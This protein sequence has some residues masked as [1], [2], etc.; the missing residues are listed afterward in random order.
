MR[1][2]FVIGFF[3]ISVLSC[4]VYSQSLKNLE[5]A[6]INVAQEAG[7]AVVSISATVR[8]K[9]EGIPF[10]GMSF[11]SFGDE[12]FR[13]FFEEFFG[14]LPQR[15]YIRVG[16]GSGLII[17]KDGYILTNEHV[18]AGAGEIKV[19]LSDGREFDAVIRGKDKRSDLA[20]IKI[21][22]DN[23]LVAKLG[24]SNELKIGQWSLAIG[25]PFGFA[26]VNPEPT[27]TLGVISALHRSLPVLRRRDRSYDDLIQTDAAINPGN[28]GGPLV[29]LEGE[30]IG[31]NTAIITTS[32]S[33]QGVGFAIPINKAKKILKKL[34]RGEK[35]F[36][37]WL[38]VS[39]QDLNEDLRSY[40]GI[41]EREGVIVVK[42]FKDSPGERAKIKEGDL[43]LSFDRKPIKAS[44]NLVRMMTSTQVG[45]KIPLV[46]LRSGKKITLK[47]KVGKRL[48]DTA[49]PK[50]DQAGVAF[51][52]MSVESITPDLRQKFGIKEEQGVL[53]VSIEDNSLADKSGLE[54][55][56]V[57]LSIQGSP[58]K[59]KNDFKDLIS[60]IK[61]KCLIKTSRG[62][63]VLKEE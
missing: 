15:E 17:N 11:E 44:R 35:I 34:I 58:I 49:G 30:V 2:V 46:I 23:L 47:L 29:N 3:L 14:E 22:A 32:G 51:R 27:V 18:I 10:Q 63:F 55:G 41:K 54:I 39:I 28:S 50:I 19:K 56:E 12:F 31:I 25:N 26:I 24:N 42:V 37:G 59:S 1:I 7:K 43:I 38:G 20:I 33:Y 13:N 6:T 61:G 52:G 60:G 48:E 40:F 16:L 53:I 57:I 9:I 4:E 21:E 36:Y 62:Y 5:Q 8:Q 45:E